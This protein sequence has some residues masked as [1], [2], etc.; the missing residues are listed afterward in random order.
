MTVL[1]RAR[2]LRQRGL[3]VFSVPLGSKIPTYTWKVFQTTLPSDDELVEMFAEP[4][5]IAIVTGAVSRLVVIDA[6]SDEARRYIVRRLPSTPWQTMTVRGQHFCYR[7]PG[8]PVPNRQLLHCR[9]PAGIF[10]IDVKGDGGYVLAPGS[11]HPSGHPYVAAGNW[12]CPVTV[13]PVFSPDWFPASR[14]TTPPAAGREPRLS[15]VGSFDAFFLERARKYLATLPLPQIGQ[16]S[17][18]ATFIAAGRL[19]RGFALSATDAEQL[20][21]EWCGSRE[22]WDRDWVRQKVANALKHGSEAVG[23]LR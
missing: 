5:N 12:N 22:G 18:T 15:T 21:W 2:A 20:L 23:G 8:V 14:P 1:E 13:L 19:V 7:H 16:G 9:T 6:D 3:S 4:A 11:I 10:P 17:D